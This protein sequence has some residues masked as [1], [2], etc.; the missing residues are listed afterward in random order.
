MPIHGQNL[1]KSSFK[2]N[3][4]L[5]ILKLGLEH[6]GRKVHKIYRNND[7]GSYETV[8]V[9]MAKTVKFHLM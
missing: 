1:Y 9:Y 8:C 7:P 6:L 3:R 5:I 4:N 2:K